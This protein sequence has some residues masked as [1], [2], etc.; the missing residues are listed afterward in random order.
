[1][2]TKILGVILSIIG[3]AI[4]I[5]ILANAD[6]LM[7]QE[8]NLENLV[9]PGGKLGEFLHGTLVMKDKSGNLIL[10]PSLSLATHTHPGVDIIADCGSS[11]YAF[12]N[13][14]VTDMIDTDKDRDFPFLGYMVLVRHAT[15]INDKETYSI[16]LH[17]QAPPKVTIGQEVKAGQ[18]VLGLVG[19]TG[20]VTGCHTHFE[21]R[22][23]ATRYLTDSEWN[24]PWN[25][26]G[27][28]D[29]RDTH[30]FREN[31]EDP[32]ALQERIKLSKVDKQPQSQGIQYGVYVNEKD[33]SNYFELR[34]DGTVVND[35]GSIGRYQIEDSVLTLNYTYKVSGYRGGELV[36]EELV[37]K[38]I[39]RLSHNYILDE[40]GGK[41]KIWQGGNTRVDYTKKFSL[42]LVIN[43]GQT[44]N[45][46]TLEKDGFVYLDGKRLVNF[47]KGFECVK[48]SPLSPSERFFIAMSWD[49]DKGGIEVFIIDLK[50]KS[51]VARYNSNW[52][53]YPIPSFADWVSW[54]P[55]E[56]YVLISPG[57]EGV[58]ELM[59]LDL[60]TGIAKEVP[61]KRLE[62]TYGKGIKEMQLTEIKTVTW[63]ND[64]MFRTHIGIFCNPYD[65]NKCR[66]KFKP[67]RIYEAKMDL[68]IGKIDYKEV[69]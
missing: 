61:L 5:L 3:V 6:S 15:P 2:K 8:K 32:I 21:I 45:G 41:W 69:K 68:D 29:Q 62:R 18:T 59:Y 19:K 51:V 1:M 27:N 56:R 4:G 35:R 53:G 43:R 40:S 47:K 67:R 9:V 64:H 22:H 58:R 50:N 66:G 60:K 13:G 10:A 20:S 65:D 12:A 54:S 11:I 31:W 14:Y 49:F 36:E 48:L 23:F 17:M 52:R 24:R 44:E 26:Y 37:S 30:R 63:V 55:S 34:S 42:W 28:G 33:K 39:F 46:F 7:A 25:I 57:G 38:E 16:Y